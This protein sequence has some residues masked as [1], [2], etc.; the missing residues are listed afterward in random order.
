MPRYRFSL[1]IYGQTLREGAWINL[2]DKNAA[3]NKA[4]QLVQALLNFGS[5]TVPWTDGVLVVESSDGCET[6]HVPIVPAV[7]GKVTVRRH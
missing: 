5:G 7:E 2:A 4:H 3:L 6:I 1:S